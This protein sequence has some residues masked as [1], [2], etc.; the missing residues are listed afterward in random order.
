MNIVLNKYAT[1]L[2]QFV[3]VLVL[4]VQASM[5]EGISTVE[6]WQLGAVA[7]ANVGTY[8]VPLLSSGWIGAGKT[9]V[10]ILGAIVAA[11]IPLVNNAWTAETITI[12][13]LAGLNAL[14]AQAGVGIRVDSSKAQLAAPEVADVV[15]VTVD[16]DAVKAAVPDATVVHAV[17]AKLGQ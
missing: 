6:A 15:P 1:A 12:V 3:L 9:G 11:I 17:D 7:I 4:A 8:F 2:L 13:I 5:S 14:A 10:A 16:V